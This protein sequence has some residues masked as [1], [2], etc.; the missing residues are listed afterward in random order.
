MGHHILLYMLVGKGF[1]F[2]LAVQA[3]HTKSQ[4]V[5]HSRSCSD[6]LIAGNAGE[7]HNNVRM[8]WGK[9][10]LPWSPDADTAIKRTVFLNHKYALVGPAHAFP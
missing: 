4:L 7:L 2:F 3:S 10:I 5:G 9:A 1:P 8:T 6:K